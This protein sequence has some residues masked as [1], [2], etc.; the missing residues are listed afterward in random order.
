MRPIVLP[1]RSDDMRLKHIGLSV[2]ALLL[3]ASTLGQ[4]PPKGHWVRSEV[5]GTLELPAGQADGSPHPDCP[6]AKC[7]TVRVR[8]PVG[9]SFG[10]PET[11]LRLVLP[12]ARANVKIRTREGPKP[13]SPFW[14]TGCRRIIN[15][16]NILVDAT[17]EWSCDDHYARFEGPYTASVD[18]QDH[19]MM[20]VTVRFFNW[21][22]YSQMGKFIIHYSQWQADK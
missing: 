19:S 14:W 5:S 13:V 1:A 6:P 8:V 21:A 4:A 15:P 17:L 9:S 3:V 11:Q 10:S 12:K 16:Q 22:S 2:I 18:P 20:L 7:G